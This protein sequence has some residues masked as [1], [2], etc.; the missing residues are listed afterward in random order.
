VKYVIWSLVIVLIVIAGLAVISRILA[1]FT[2]LLGHTPTVEKNQAG[3]NRDLPS[4]VE[5]KNAPATVQEAARQ[6]TWADGNSI[7]AL[8]LARV[9]VGGRRFVTAEIE[10]T[11][12]R[13]PEVYWV[14]ISRKY[15]WIQIGD[16]TL[17]PPSIEGAADLD[18]T[19][20]LWSDDS[21]GLGRKSHELLRAIPASQRVVAG[22]GHIIK[23]SFRLPN[24]FQASDDGWQRIH[25]VGMTNWSFNDAPQIWGSMQADAQDF[26]TWDADLFV[27]TSI[28]P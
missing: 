14:G 1:P 7:Y 27:P 10:F 13:T 8:R 18:S 26:P 9:T 17:N 28:N 25:I 3:A 16:L 4:T 21:G 23:L 12:S 22:I 19:L 5:L 11:P 15:T 2:A 24:G 20:R 6:K